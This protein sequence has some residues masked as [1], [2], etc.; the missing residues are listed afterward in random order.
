M[1]KFSTLTLLG[2]WNS[3]IIVLFDAHSVAEVAVAA[4]G[5]FIRHYYLLPV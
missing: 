2:C 1:P 5:F 3:S 4:D